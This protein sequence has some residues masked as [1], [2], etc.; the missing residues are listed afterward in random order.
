[1]NFLGGEVSPN[2]YKRLDMAGNGKWFETAKNIY[3]GTTGDI[4]NR[5]G[6]QYIA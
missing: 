2:A 5:R 4:Y 1:M 3:F 6:F